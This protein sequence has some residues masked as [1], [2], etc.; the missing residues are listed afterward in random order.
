M[1][2]LRVDRASRD[3]VRALLRTCCGSS[4]WVERMLDRRPFGTGDVLLAAARAEWFAL[5]PADWK[6]AFAAHPKIG[7]RDALT[8]RFPDTSHLAAGEQSGV[9]GA[10]EDVLTAL[11]AANAAYEMTFGYIFIVCASGLTAEQM[12]AMLRDRLENDPATELRIAAEEQAKI[13]ALRLKRL[14]V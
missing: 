14:Q 5:D 12:L 13:T 3:E 4:R 9:D 11:A 7:D 10:P 1:A 6:E 8:H 2:P